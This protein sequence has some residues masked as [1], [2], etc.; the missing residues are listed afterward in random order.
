[1]RKLAIIFFLLTVAAIGQAAT[2]TISGTVLDAQH[3]A[4][5]QAVV[6]VVAAG[7]GGARVLRTGADGRFTAAQLVA[8]SY[9]VNATA[10]G[11]KLPRPERVTLGVGG[12]IT[13]TL[14]LGVA[15]AGQQVTVTGRAALVEGQTTAPAVNKRSPQVANAV[16]GLHVTYMPNRSRE[17]REFGMLSG[18]SADTDQGLSVAGQRPQATKIEVDGFNFNDPLEGGARGAKDGGLFFPQTAVQEMSLVHSGADA[19]VGETNGGFFNV[20]TKPGDK[21]LRGEEFLILRPHQ[22]SGRDAFG[23]ALDNTVSEYGL[24][25]GYHLRQIFYYFGIEHDDSDVP[26]YTAF[27]PQA[28]GVVVPPALLALQGETVGHNTPTALSLRT[29]VNLGPHTTLTLQGNYNY[30]RFSNYDPGSTQV[31]AAPSA[32]SSL[33]GQSDWLR[34]NLTSTLGFGV[35][36]QVLAQWGG[37]RR[38]FMPNSLAPEVFINGFGIL[39]GGALAG[40]RYVSG[41]RGASDE[42]TFTWHGHLIHVGGG[43]F[44]DPGTEFEQA[45]RNGRYDY[46]SLVDY[47]AG[48]A[49]R[50]QQTFAA[51]AGSLLYQAT[52]RRGDLYFNDRVSLADDLALT[53]GLRWDGQWNPQPSHPNAAIPGTSLI[54]NDLAQWQPRLGLAW[55]PRTNTVLR[56]SAGLYD[57]PTP[58]TDFNRIFTDNGLNAVMAD[59]TYDPS[60]LA[61]AAAGQGLSA[62]PPGLT[63]PAALAV[64]ITPGFRNPR[65]FQ[66]AASLQQELGKHVD[67]TT[68]FTHNSTSNLE[69]MVEANLNPPALDASGMPVFPLT[70]PM[71]NVGQLLLTESNG[72]STYDG[73]ATTANLELPYS[74]GL[75]ANYTL[76]RTRDDASQQGPFGVVTALDPFDLALEAAYANQDIRHNLNISGTDRLPLGF[77]VN[78]IFMWRSG[79]PYTPI[80]G[81]DTQNDGNDRNDRALLA[82][83]VAGRNSL[84]QPDLYDL[85]IRFVK[86]FTLGRGRHLDLFLDVFNFTN[87]GNRAFAPDALDVY[88]TPAAPVFSAGMPLFAPSTSAF[89]GPRSIQFTARM[90][91]F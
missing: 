68:G 21:R 5:P 73:W 16:A 17:F 87:H 25:V 2:G 37:D 65:S 39:G 34:L 23:H 36:N 4:V 49:R 33:S 7:V 55:N 78:P 60:L 91:E 18:S 8:G 74:L 66:A 88:G 57:A 42:A 48:T 89:G 41:Q 43:W 83:Q 14:L 13:L 9:T 30:V 44:D 10:P 80:I 22:V 64:A 27:Q 56:W 61:L 54:P 20:A 28:P 81:F 70:R 59:S 71:P 62:P 82:G 47:L 67:L 1:M 46:N 45:N 72:H 31:W 40:H 6:T 29:D 3:K 86:D 84:R 26:Y 32:G 63:T 35:V 79:L 90:V 69:R 19:A 24:G 58:A 38:D 12:S 51:A 85:D 76:A 77:K 75:M 11:L 52:G 50:F 53:A 15:Q